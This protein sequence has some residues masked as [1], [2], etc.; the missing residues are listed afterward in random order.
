MQPTANGISPRTK[1]SRL[2]NLLK[3]P[4][5]YQSPG[6]SF[7][8]ISA[9]GSTK[10]RK[11]KGNGFVPTLKTGSM[12]NG[13]DIPPIGL[14]NRTKRERIGLNDT[15]NNTLGNTTVASVRLNQSQQVDSLVT[16][17]PNE[18]SAR[19]PSPR[20]NVRLNSSRQRS[21]PVQLFESL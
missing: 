11:T 6:R 19:R 12:V 8:R 16:K 9:K 4:R 7:L 17:L 1:I 13:L 20:T 2:K 15:L 14:P 10:A 18:D 5:N 21:D 3:T